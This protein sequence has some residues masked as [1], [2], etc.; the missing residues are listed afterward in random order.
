MFQLIDPPII[1]QQYPYLS[2]HIPWLPLGKFPTPVHRLVKLE[3]ALGFD[4]LWIKRD[5]QSGALGGG[6][7]I[8]PPP[9]GWG[10]LPDRELNC[11]IDKVSHPKVDLRPLLQG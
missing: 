7:D 2:K 4:S 11:A 8:L 3:R 6:I 1:F 5:D 10:F 9:K